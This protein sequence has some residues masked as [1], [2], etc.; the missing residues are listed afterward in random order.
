MSAKATFSSEGRFFGRR[1]SELY[2]FLRAQ[3]EP[4]WDSCFRTSKC[5]EGFFFPPGILPQW[6]AP[7]KTNGKKG[8]SSL[9]SKAT[10]HNS[11]QLILGPFD[12]TLKLKPSAIPHKSKHHNRITESNRHGAKYILPSASHSF[13][14]ERPHCLLRDFPSIPTMPWAL[15][16]LSGELYHPVSLRPNLCSPPPFVWNHRFYQTWNWWWLPVSQSPVT[17]WRQFELRYLS[18]PNHFCLFLF[19]IKNE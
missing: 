9:P 2:S 5:K 6:S 15:R 11:H 7:E 13:S 17:E 14:Q 4:A 18:A 10:L 1:Q 16:M 3:R 19:T 12:R 8:L